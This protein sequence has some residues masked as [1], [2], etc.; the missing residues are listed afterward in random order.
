[1]PRS[2]ESVD[3]SP[4]PPSS[5]GNPAT[6][7]GPQL[8]R[9]RGILAGIEQTRGTKILVLLGEISQGSCL[10]AIRVLRRVGH[11]KKLEVIL[12][13]PGGDLDSAIKLTRI[14]RAHCDVLS[15]IVPFYAKSAATLVAI[16]ADELHMT[17]YAEV[18]PIDPQVADPQ[19]G[20]PIPAHSIAQA[21]KFISSCEDRLVKLSLT[22][23]LSPLLIGAYKEIELATIQEVDE[24]CQRLANP[25]PALHAFTSKYLSHGY[26]LTADALKGLGFPVEMMDLTVSNAF[27]DLHDLCLP[28]T[29]LHDH[30]EAGHCVEPIAALTTECQSCLL[31]NEFFLEKLPAAESLA[32]V[33]TTPTDG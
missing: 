7:Y 23:K 11:V 2:H 20:Y 4:E 15:V 8:E 33:I 32:P 16:S 22:E 31:E 29:H 12:D 28:F 24:V 17:P 21:L 25:K 14:L 19:T 27:M 26:P 5:S 6:R 30:D 10:V 18:G 9:G 13:S 3:V 1:M